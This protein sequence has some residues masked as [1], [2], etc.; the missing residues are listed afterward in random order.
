M[1][2]RTATRRLNYR[3]PHF[4]KFR[5]PLVYGSAET[6]PR[7]ETRGQSPHTRKGPP[8]PPSKVYTSTDYFGV[9]LGPR[10][11]KTART[12]PLGCP[13]IFSCPYNRVRLHAEVICCIQKCLSFLKI[14]LI[15]GCFWAYLGCYLGPG[16]HNVTSEPVW[17]VSALENHG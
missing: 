8:T 2:H 13:I 7:T 4:K 11:P 5:D 12:V 17:H 15:L 6:S 1:K 3:S 9:F 10:G 14:H 16:T